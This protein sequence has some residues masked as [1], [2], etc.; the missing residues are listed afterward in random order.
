MSKGYNILDCGDL[1]TQIS[2]YF[3]VMFL[4][5][6]DG[7]VNAIIVIRRDLRFCLKRM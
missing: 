7:T 5:A 1:N 3:V 2:L 4:M 6:A